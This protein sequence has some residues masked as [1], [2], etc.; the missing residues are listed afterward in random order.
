MLSTFFFYSFIF[1][2]LGFGV[3]RYVQSIKESIPR[4]MTTDDQIT[5]I[6]F[7]DQGISTRFY[8]PEEMEWFLNDQEIKSRDF[9]EF[10]EQAAYIQ[11]LLDSSQ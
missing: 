7:P 11:E 9:I 6:T 4:V 8:T 2:I 1:I 5:Y 3:D 10:R